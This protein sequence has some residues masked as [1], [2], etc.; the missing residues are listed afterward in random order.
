MAGLRDDNICV[1][2]GEQQ[3][4]RQ[5]K[6]KTTSN[7]EAEVRAALRVVGQEEAW[8]MGRGRNGP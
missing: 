6:E 3:V 8:V 2:G 5:R 4:Y 1:R 7:R